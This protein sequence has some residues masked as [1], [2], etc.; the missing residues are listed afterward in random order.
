V[1]WQIAG[2]I[3]PHG[4][5]GVDAHGWL[6]EIRRGPEWPEG[7]VRRVLVEV[8]G[9]AWSV[10][11]ATL[12][13]ETAAAIQ[14]EGKSEVERVLGLEEPPQIILCTTVGCSPREPTAQTDL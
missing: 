10:D 9:S 7:D 1:P 4:S 5:S 12:A 14:S 2:Q 13:D 3:G 11:P 6:W 8:S